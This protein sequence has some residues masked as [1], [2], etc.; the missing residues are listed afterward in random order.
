M[1]IAL[2]QKNGYPAPFIGTKE[3]CMRR[4]LTINAMLWNV[5]T[6]QLEDPFNG[7]K[8]LDNRLLK[9]THNEHFAEDPL[10][11]FRVAQFAGRFQCDVDPDLQILCRR[12]TQ[13]PAFVTIPDDNIQSCCAVCF[14]PR[15]VKPGFRD[16]A[17]KTVNQLSALPPFFMGGR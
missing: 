4:D 12:L 1:D 10:R 5:E 11:V 2:P 8:D 14:D 7:R 15:S 16:S 6:N 17:L 9:A 13:N 3:A